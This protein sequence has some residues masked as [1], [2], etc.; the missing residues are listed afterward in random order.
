MCFNSGPLSVR[1]IKATEEGQHVGIGPQLIQVLSCLPRQHGR[2]AAVA[3]LAHAGEAHQDVGMGQLALRPLIEVQN[4]TGDGL[5]L[6]KEAGTGS[7]HG[8]VSCTVGKGVHLYLMVRDGVTEIQAMVQERDGFE[9]IALALEQFPRLERT[10]SKVRG[11][12]RSRNRYFAVIPP[13]FCSNFT[14]TVM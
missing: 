8:M 7:A 3:H 6:R 11:A 13:L 4:E 2:C 14:V 10:A 9:G 5:S 1:R 12:Q